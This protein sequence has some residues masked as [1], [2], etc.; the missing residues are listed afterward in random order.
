MMIFID[1]VLKYRKRL[2]LVIE[3]DRNSDIVVMLGIRSFFFK[4]ISLR[5]GNSTM[6]ASKY[7][8]KTEFFII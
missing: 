4:E 6:H 7:Q 2:K 1:R 3:N 8:M 5:S